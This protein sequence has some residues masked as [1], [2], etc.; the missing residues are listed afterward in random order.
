MKKEHP[1]QV[2]GK[3]NGKGNGQPRYLVL[4]D[5][6]QTMIEAGTLRPGDRIPSI[7]HL[8]E[9]YR[10]SIPTVLHAYTVL[11]DRRLVEARPKSG[12]Y[13]RA[14]LSSGTEVPSFSRRIPSP[15]TLSRFAPLMALVDDV[16]NPR[17]VPMGG[18]NPSPALLPSEKLARITGAIARRQARA[19]VQYDPPPG[20]P[21]LRREISRRSVEWGTY[22]PPEDFL[23]TN[24]ATEA[25]HLAL[26]TVAKPGDTV[27]VES[28]I[29]YGIL[30]LLSRLGLRT[31]AVPS[32]PREGLPIGAVRKVLERE[33]VAA[34]I[35]IPNFSNPLGSLMPE[36]ARAELVALAAQRQIPIIEDD[37]YGDLSHRGERPACLKSLDADGGVLLC[38]SFSKTLAPGYRAGYIAGGRWHRE[39]LEAKVALTFGG[40]PL[41]SLAIAEFLRNGGYDHHLR[42]LRATFREQILR[43]REAV[44]AAFPREA[45]IS[46][47]QGGFVLWIE[48]ARQVDSMVL[49]EKAREAGISIAPGHLF[50]PAAEFRNCIRLSC[51]HPRTPAMEKAVATLG[52]LAKRMSG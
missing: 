44:A 19:V 33:K 9:R 7:R 22:L 52:E 24:G 4:A 25:L 40:S 3:E 20:C 23:L 14:R 37:I 1:V 21:A 41:P 42:R 35:V 32:S 34:L 50:S 46:D 13:V 26:R 45:K 10:V 28:P 8:S 49:F 48:L 29:Y 18:A 16:A 6:V 39:I 31:V 11:E 36:A 5:E 27:M 47:P 30:H 12:F 51:G 38:G 2:N 15:K 43:M 17:L